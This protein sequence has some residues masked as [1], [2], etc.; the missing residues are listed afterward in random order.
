MNMSAIHDHRVNA[1]PILI[2]W[3]LRLRF[4]VAFVWVLCVGI[5]ENTYIILLAGVIAIAILLLLKV[6]V[7]CLFKRI[8]IITPFILI[9]FLTLLISDGFPIT[10]DAFE[11]SILILCR[12]LTSVIVITI[13]SVDDIKN[14]LDSFASMGLSSALISTL[15]LAQRYVHLL[16][17]ELSSLRDALSSRLFKAKFGIR[18]MKIYGQIV[19][20]MTVKAIDRSGH[21][22]HAMMSRGFDGRVRTDKA[23]AINISDLFKSIAAMGTIIF[24]VFVERGL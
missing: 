18:S 5:M 21:I 8:F 6:P 11:F 9:T 23:P 10:A 3:D 16:N 24:L 22:Q 1:K 4:L 17:K 14:Y 19:G 20:G 12:V 15:F 13:V 2:N 7:M